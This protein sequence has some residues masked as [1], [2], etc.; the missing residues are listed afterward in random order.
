MCNSESSLRPEPTLW[1]NGRFVPA[2]RAWIS[3]ADRGFLYGDG[4]FETLRV[5]QGA[6]LYLEEHLDRLRGSLEAFRIRVDLDLD[7]PSIVGEV[8]ER[9]GL[10]NGVAAVKIVVTRGEAAGLGLPD[11]AEPTVMASAREY[12]EL[13]YDKGWKL[14]V[15]Q[16]G[17]SPPLSRHK[18]LNYMYCMFAR[19]AALDAGA[20]EGVMLD[21]RGE[22]AE[23]AAGSL[24]ARLGG[25]WVRP[26]TPQQLA[27]TTIALVAR[28][29]EERGTP[30]TPHPLSV[31][32]LRSAETVWVLNSLM[33]V[34]PVR[35]VDGASVKEP[36]RE[37]A[38]RVRRL[39]FDRGRRGARSH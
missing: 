23:T 4:L 7:W 15:V 19:Q 25:R 29:L 33:G 6:A 39:L 27:G 16:E 26:G 11:A 37:E 17:Y 24:V 21:P 1:I 22:V 28:V 32:E 38:A 34:M 2:R 8:V 13:D 9:S 30:V 14:H 20:D 36:R 31:E 35:A 3:P 10:F 12:H 5:E 18:S